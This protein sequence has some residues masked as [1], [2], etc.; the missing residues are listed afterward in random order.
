VNTDWLIQD[1]GAYGR[2]LT[3]GLPEYP[4]WFGCDNCYA[5]QGVLAMGETKLCRDT[6]ELILAYSEK[7]NGNGRILHE[8]TTGG[9]CVNPGNTQETAHFL[10]AVFAYYQWTGDTDFIARAYPYLQKS[11][12][13][14]NNQDTDNDLFPSGY[15]IIEIAGLHSELIDSA[16]Y[17]CV[18][19]SCYA[20]ICR[21]MGNEAEAMPWEEKAERLKEAINKKMWDEEAGLYCDAFTSYPEVAKNQATILGKVRGALR[22][23]VSACFQALLEK[24]KP[25]GDTESGWLINRNWVINTPMEM[26]IAPKEKAERA[27]KRMHTPEFIGPYGMYLSALLQGSAMTISTGVMAVAQARYGHSDR[28]LELIKRMFSTFSRSTPGTISEMSPD[29]GCFVQAWTAYAVMVPIVLYFFGV[30]P[31]AY[32]GRVVIDPCMPAEWKQASLKNVHVPGGILNLDYQENEGRKSL[33][34]SGSCEKP[35]YFSLMPEAAWEVNGHVYGPSSKRE[36]IL[37]GPLS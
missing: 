13:W 23:D 6:L 2:G 32:H 20:R 4:W 30:Q 3:A 19:Y 15:G 33:T 24:K 5:L 8:V 36:L 29:Y 37:I 27:L 25:L 11:V 22:P 1:S 14:L 12:A 18:A 31:D 21:L 26:G 34:I 17:T 35:L 9:V 10:T 28:A 16:V 7:H